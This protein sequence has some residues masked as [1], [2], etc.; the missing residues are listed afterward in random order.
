[1]HLLDKT[2]QAGEILVEIIRAMPR[3]EKNG[4]H[5]QMSHIEPKPPGRTLG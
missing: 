2:D 4:Q 1:M 5:E 3:A